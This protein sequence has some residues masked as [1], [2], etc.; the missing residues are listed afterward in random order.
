MTKVPARTYDGRK[1][2]HC[3]TSTEQSFLRKM[4]KPDEKWNKG[5][6]IL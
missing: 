5:T 2:K 6:L 1:A 4:I 3:V